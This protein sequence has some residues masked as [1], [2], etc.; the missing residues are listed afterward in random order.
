MDSGDLSKYNEFLYYI[1]KYLTWNDAFTSQDVTYQQLRNSGSFRYIKNVSLYKKIVEYY[2]LYSRYQ[3]IDQFGSTVDNDFLEFSLKVFN[4][5]DF[6]NI[7][8]SG[9]TFYD[10]ARPTGKLHPISTDKQNLKLLYTKFAN[11]SDKASGCI[12]FLGWLK[13]MST[14]VMN[15]LKNEY[16]IK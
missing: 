6:H 5:K 13:A 10:I 11:A 15:D 7:G 14:D 9:N 3:S 4:Q 8:F 2:N 16:H 1:G 12:A